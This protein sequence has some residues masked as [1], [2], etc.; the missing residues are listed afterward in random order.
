MS[1]AQDMLNAQDNTTSAQDNE[2]SA[3][4]NV[5]CAHDNESS[6]KLYYVEHSR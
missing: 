1:K 4:D 3:H 5:L 6:A 2:S